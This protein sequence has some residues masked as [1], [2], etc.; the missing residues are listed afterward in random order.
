[1]TKASQATPAAPT[2]EVNLSQRQIRLIFSG[3]M[4]GIFLAALDQTIVGT[5]IRTIADD[6]SGLSIQAWVTTA[7]LITSTITTPLYGK[8]S[9]IFG[10][11]PLFTLAISIFILGSLLC[12]FSTSMYMLAGFRAIQGLGAG[13]LFSLALAI[14][15]DIV[16]PRERAKYQGYFLAVFGT[17]SVL[18][19]VV[20]GF[21]AGADS[22]LGIVG[23]RWVFLVNVPIGF[24]ALLVVQRTLNIAHF[25]RKNR[26]D[27]GGAAALTMA[28]VPLLT[29]AEQGRIWGWSSARSISCFAIGLL[30]AGVFFAVERA[31]G[32]DALIPLRLFQSKTMNVATLG[33]VVIGMGLFGGIATLPLYL[34]IVRGSSP[35]TAGLQLIPLTLGI[36]AS[37]VIS[38]RVIS[39]TGRYRHFPIIGAGL[40]TLGLVLFTQLSAESPLWLAMLMMAVFGLGLGNCLQP[41]VLALQNSV[42]PA[43]LGIATASATFFRQIGGTLGVAV[44]LS[45]LFSSLP[46]NLRSAINAALGTGEFQRA[47]A[48]PANAG[49]AENLRNG[50]YN[51]ADAV[52]DSSFLNGLD[53]RL[54]KPF[55]AAFADSMH[56]V[57]WSA[58]AVMLIG[59]IVVCFLP[60][61]ELRKTTGLQAAAAERAHSAGAG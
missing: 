38:G 24:L 27:W 43:D 6:L 48:D 16:S 32:D 13:G 39:R 41:L 47:L 30:G 35:T 10:R 34:Q 31:M 36:M 26:I 49:F 37:S 54:A 9:D 23:W 56:M 12:A 1:M 28:L 52:N 3:L 17:S 44:F 40:M 59:L 42:A 29:V 5:A 8:L 50:T 33:N 55:Q 4:L 2:P 20:G 61:I 18:G 15:G 46:G 25:P 57:F 7:Y 22:V 14:V 21:F 58:S 11:K 53:E 60:H 51:S 19:P 45:L